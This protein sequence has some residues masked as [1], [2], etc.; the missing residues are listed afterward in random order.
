MMSQLI[1]AQGIHY[2][3]ILTISPK[4]YCALKNIKRGVNPRKSTKP[5]FKD[6]DTDAFS[7]DAEGFFFL[8]YMRNN[9]TI[10]VSLPSANTS[11][12]PLTHLDSNAAP[13][14]RHIVP[15]SDASARV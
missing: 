10:H 1:I 2:T 9:A 8:G 12:V 14:A 13:A 5:F 15:S 7:Y 11:Q 6:I 3:L 4:I